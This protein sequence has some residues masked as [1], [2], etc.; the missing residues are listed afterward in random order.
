MQEG[1]EGSSLPSLY[2]PYC[3]LLRFTASVYGGS[4][5]ILAH[6]SF[7]RAVPEAHLVQQLHTPEKQLSMQAT[8]IFCCIGL[9][10]L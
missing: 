4:I 3:V 8:L 2:V 10:M 7:A 5:S 6:K 9:T 1:C